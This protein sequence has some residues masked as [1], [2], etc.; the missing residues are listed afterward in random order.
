MELCMTDRQIIARVKR[1]REFRAF[2][3]LSHA[4][5]VLLENAREQREGWLYEC[6]AS[7][8]ISAFKVEAYINHAGKAL[9]PYWDEMDRLPVKSKLNIIRSHLGM[10]TKDGQRPFQTLH[11]LFEFRN[12][13]AHCRDE[14]LDPPESIE[15]GDVEEIRRKY[16]Q[17]S[18]ES[19]CTVE[20]A[21]RANKDTEDIIKELHSKAGLPENDL[22][23]AGHGYSLRRHQ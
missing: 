6:M 11:D 7:I 16:P 10:D 15:E 9:F 22:R 3:E 17:T 21:E 8:L 5:W 12:D 2:A 13:L 20:F 18:W 19:K 1:K 4:D 14:I 23:R